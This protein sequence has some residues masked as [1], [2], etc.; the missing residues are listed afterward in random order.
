MAS[1][2]TFLSGSLWAGPVAVH[3]LHLVLSVPRLAARAGLVASL[4]PLTTSETGR[5]FQRI[6]DTI[7]ATL[8]GSVVVAIVQGT[9]GGLIFWMLGYP[10]RW[11]GA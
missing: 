9:S 8:Y 11:S 1:V 10:R 6:E 3:R 7:F 4:L 2:P 5:T